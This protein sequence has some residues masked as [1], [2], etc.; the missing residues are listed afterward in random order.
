[1]KTPPLAVLLLVTTLPLSAARDRS[2]QHAPPE[3]YLPGDPLPYFGSENPWD[4]RWFFTPVLQ[5]TRA[6]QRAQ[7]LL[8]EGRAAEAERF[9]RARLAEFPLELESHFN[10]AVALAA[11]GRTDE[12]G[13][14]LAGALDLGLPPSRVLAGPRAQ[15]APLR[16]T[17]AYR[18]A[19]EACQGLV[20]GPLLGAVTPAAARFWVRT[21]EESAVE[22]RLS[23]TGDF[24]APEARGTART[25]ARDDY[26]AVV[27]VDGLAARTPYLYQIYLDGRPVPRDEVWRFVTPPPEAAPGPVRVAFGG[28]AQYE[29]ARERIWDTIRLRR[30][31]AFL[32]MGDNV[33]VDLPRAI[34]PFHRYTYYQRQSRPEFR[35]LTA[36]VPVYAFWD[37]HDAGIDDVFLG[38]YPD[39]PAWKLEWFHHFREN[40]NN[41]A[42]GG[43]PEH[44][45]LWHRFRIGPVECFMLDGRYYRENFLKPNPSMLGPVQ[46]AWLLQSLRESTA[47]FKLLVS[48]VAWADDAKIEQTSWGEAIPAQDI[49]SGYRA[50]REEI[51]A[52]LADHH[53]GGVLLLSSDRHRHDV[54]LNRRARG[55]P[56]LEF[57][58]GWLT[59]ETG[60]EGSGRPLFEY[61]D[62]PAF[63]FFT[64]DAS[65]PA[66][67]A[68]FE[69]VNADGEAV[70]RRDVPLAE[71]TDAAQ[72]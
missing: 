69:L 34:G 12:A 47:P 29:P 48:P 51:F 62:G 56:L 33:Y 52:F 58:S 35:R 17:P 64:F 57:E 66:P 1:M 27:A 65:G 24:A 60:T 41:P 13:A 14:A 26:T 32:L 63:G 50:E 31:D 54:R 8:L 55:Y 46:K 2:P 59:N 22:V 10:L 36:G 25:R 4:Q 3:A 42:Y 71:L 28:C 70:Y 18:R 44:P 43:A 5:E 23:R 11:L 7:L 61:L 45:G 16:A 30:P 38:P 15:L 6:G 53:I 20:H 68:R 49:W 67:G 9:C 37:D 39:R 19:R 40:W 21:E 72:P